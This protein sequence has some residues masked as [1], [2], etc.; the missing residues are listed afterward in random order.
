[1]SGLYGHFGREA[2][3][4]KYAG[5]GLDA[6]EAWATEQGKL[7]G[8]RDEKGRSKVGIA[9]LDHNENNWLLLKDALEENETLEAWLINKQL[10]DG[11]SSSYVMEYT[12]HG[13]EAG[14]QDYLA[15]I[16]SL[17]N[18]VGS[19]V[20][21]IST[22][23]EETGQ[24][25]PEQNSGDGMYFIHVISQLLS[26]CD[27]ALDYVNVFTDLAR[28]EYSL[29]SVFFL[30]ET[31]Q[32]VLVRSREHADRLGAEPYLWFAYTLDGIVFA[33]RPESITINYPD[34]VV[35]EVAEE[36]VLIFD[37]Q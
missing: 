32:L 18:V 22:Y 28:L 13:G 16:V 34:A 27:S 5:S 30:P 29:H 7:K 12:A 35:Q 6:L 37:L 26:E 10:V 14:V 3:P 17:P 19:A 21:Y 4:V 25:N 20:G 36:Q 9:V 1:M 8:L 23:L 2:Q 24:S 31:D 11:T 15:P 33:S